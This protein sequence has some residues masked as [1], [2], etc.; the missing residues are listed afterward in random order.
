M[1]W[2]LLSFI[3]DGNPFFEVNDWNYFSFGRL[4]PNNRLYELMS[5]A[6]K[7]YLDDDMLLV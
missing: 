2:N 7:V 4:S 5:T 3:E 6:I 1:E